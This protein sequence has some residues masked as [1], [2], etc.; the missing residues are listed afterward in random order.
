MQDAVK[1]SDRSYLLDNSSRT[2]PFQQIAV[3]AGTQVNR[4]EDPL[5]AWAKEILQ[6]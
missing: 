6:E 5:P 2:N 3:I 4:L 1:M